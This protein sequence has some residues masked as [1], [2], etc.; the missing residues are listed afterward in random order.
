MAFAQQALFFVAFRV[1][2]DGYQHTHTMQLNTLD[3]PIYAKAQ[4]V[5]M[6]PDMR[7]LQLKKL[8]DYEELTDLTAKNIR[9]GGDSF[10][11]LQ[12]D[13]HLLT[14]KQV[15]K[16]YAAQGLEAPGLT[17]PPDPQTL[18]ERAARAAAD[19]RGD[20]QL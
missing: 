16:L 2:A 17:A 4:L 5:K 9:D 20:L 14:V 8:K 19:A 13:E 15:Q 10:R 12:K 11:A 1:P 18:E 6:N 3:D 7:V